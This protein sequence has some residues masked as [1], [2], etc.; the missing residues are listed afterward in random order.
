MYGLSWD[1]RKVSKARRKDNNRCRKK[2]PA[3]VTKGTGM[4][5]TAVFLPGG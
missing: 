5:M 4:I 1:I 2:Q 3:E